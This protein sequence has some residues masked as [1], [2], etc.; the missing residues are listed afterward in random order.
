LKTV[1]VTGTPDKAVE[2]P[3]NPVQEREDEAQPL[4]P[5]ESLQPLKGLLYLGRLSKNVT[6]AGHDFHVS[7]LT[8]GQQMRVGEIIKRY[9]DTVAIDVAYKAATVAAAV[10]IVD[11]EQIYQPYDMTDNS[12]FDKKFLIVTQW[13]PFIIDE[14]FQVVLDLDSTVKEHVKRLKK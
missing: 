8:T 12:E 10:D 3:A 14:L 13:Y 6:V 11:G 5:P 2:K 4:F 7:T 9:T 1:K